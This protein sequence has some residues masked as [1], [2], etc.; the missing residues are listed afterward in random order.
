M[1][2]LNLTYHPIN[3]YRV[4]EPGDQSGEYVKAEVARELLEACEAAIAALK[5]AEY[6][7]YF[8]SPSAEA[9]VWA[10]INGYGG[11]PDIQRMIAKAR[12]EDDDN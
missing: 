9:E 1:K 8:V 7:G 3:G 12:G 5:Y 11:S 6:H 4:N 10:F 2:T